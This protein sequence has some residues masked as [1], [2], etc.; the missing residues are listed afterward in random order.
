MTEWLL[1]SCDSGRGHEIGLALSWRGRLM[2][3]AWAFICPA[4]I[5]AARYFKIMSCQNWPRVLSN[6]I[7]WQ[8]L[9]IGQ[10]TACF[11]TL[12]AVFLVWSIP[13]VVVEFH[14]VHG[15]L[16]LSLCFLQLLGAMACCS[17]GGPSDPGGMSGDHYDMTRRRLKFKRFHRS[18]GHVVLP[19][20]VITILSGLW[21]A[22]ALCWMWFSVTLYSGVLCGITLLLQR[23]GCAFATF[24]TVWGPDPAF[25]RSQ[26]AQTWWATARPGDLMNRGGD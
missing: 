15:I 3:P 4:A 5:I 9:R 26:M 11:L 24:Q 21:F 18:N 13:G 25:P 19:L 14:A 1:S 8:C 16:V 6:P 10:R 7:W 20:I 2:A 22:N 23:A 17:K 12:P